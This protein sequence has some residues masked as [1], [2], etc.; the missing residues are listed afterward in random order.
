LGGIDGVRGAQ[1]AEA[2]FRVHDA[3]EEDYKFD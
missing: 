2:G 3:L 1:V